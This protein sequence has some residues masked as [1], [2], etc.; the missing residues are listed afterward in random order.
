MRPRLRPRWRG[1][2]QSLVVNAAAYTKVDLAETELDEARRGN[3]IG[4]GVLA[5]ECARRRHSDGAR[6]DRLRV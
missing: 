1:G 6:L 4:P 5:A 2:S 3:E